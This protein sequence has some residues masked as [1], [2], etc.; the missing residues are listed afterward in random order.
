MDITRFINKKQREVLA[1]A[2]KTYGDTNQILVS[3]EELNELAAVCSKYP[4]YKTKERAQEQLREKAVDEVAD[5]LIVLDH[6]INIFGLTPVE[7]G[8]RIEGKVLRLDR[9]IHTSNS[10]EQT[11]VDRD[12]P[13]GS[14][15][16]SLFDKPCDTC[17]YQGTPRAVTI[18]CNTCGSSFKN[19]KKALPCGRCVHRGN[20]NNLKP[21]HVCSRC[22]DS[23]G[24]LFEP[25]KED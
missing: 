13:D 17:I 8:E 21:G 12:V 22:V 1:K 5:V 4:R 24:A 15:Q 19:Y 25:V 9:W 16:L 6:I 3:V 11:T 7:I 10:M 14:E 23:E 18:M 20:F 2:R